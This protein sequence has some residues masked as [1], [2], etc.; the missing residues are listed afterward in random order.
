MPGHLNGPGE[1]RSDVL[2]AISPVW[3]GQE[4]QA[5]GDQPADGVSEFGKREQENDFHA[6]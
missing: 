3:G 5:Y 1:D 4:L 2:P 6:V